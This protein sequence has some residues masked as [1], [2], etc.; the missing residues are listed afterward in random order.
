MTSFGSTLQDIVPITTSTRH[1]K[2]TVKT[3]LDGSV[4]DFEDAG[5]NAA[6]GFANGIRKGTDNVISAAEFIAHEAVSAARVVL[7]EHSPSAVFEGIGKFVSMGFA[8][9]ISAYA[10][11]AKSQ[12]KVWLVGRSPSWRRHCPTWTIRTS[13]P[14]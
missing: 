13:C 12:A 11:K 7:D 4:A 5:L 1:F 3:S 8:N 10:D 2:T 9:G 6:T 14:Q